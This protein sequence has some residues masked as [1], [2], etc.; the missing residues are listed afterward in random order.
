MPTSNMAKAPSKQQVHVFNKSQV[1]CIK[2]WQEYISN[3]HDDLPTLE[4][5]V[6]SFLNLKNKA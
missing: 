4:K 2:M 1:Q 6:F 5:H 3:L